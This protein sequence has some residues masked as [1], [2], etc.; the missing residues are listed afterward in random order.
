LEEYAG[1]KQ[2]SELIL[3]WCRIVQEYNIIPEWDIVT[4]FTDSG[5]NIKTAIETV[6]SMICEWCIL[7]LTHLALA[8]TFGSKIQNVIT[9]CQKLIE[10]VN[11]SKSLKEKK[12]QQMKQDFRI[13]VKLKNCTAHR[14]S[15][16]EM[17]L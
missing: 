8:D 9:K 5:S 16:M 14:W 17:F 6:L 2:S 7:H 10:K 3:A 13:V 4:S 15:A 11:K 1:G 12:E